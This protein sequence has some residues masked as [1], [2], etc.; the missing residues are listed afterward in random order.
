[1][2]NHSDITRE[3]LVAVAYVLYSSLCEA[4]DKPHITPQDFEVDCNRAFKEFSEE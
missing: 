1:M 4:F 3:D 2:S